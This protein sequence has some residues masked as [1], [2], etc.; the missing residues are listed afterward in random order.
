MVKHWQVTPY[1]SVPPRMLYNG[2]SWAETENKKVPSRNIH[3]RNKL[4]FLNTG[5]RKITSLV[6]KFLHEQL[7]PGKLA[8]LL[9][10]PLPN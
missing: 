3:E 4:A 9:A 8:K 5:V 7:L 10:S 1:G 6:T 2:N